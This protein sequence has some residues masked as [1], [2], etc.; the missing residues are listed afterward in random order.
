MMRKFV[1]ARTVAMLVGTLLGATAAHAA[2][3]ALLYTF[4]GG[5]GGGRPNGSLVMDRAGNLYGTTYY[6]GVVNANCPSGCG[7]VFE[8]ILGTNG[9]WTATVVHTFAG[10]NA[11]GGPLSGLTFDSVGNLYGTTSYGGNSTN[12]TGGCGTVFEL[13]PGAGTWS[14]KGIYNFT[15]SSGQTPMGRLLFDSA[16]NLYGTAFQGGSTNCSGGCG[17]VFELMPNSNGKWSWKGLHSFIGGQ[18]GWGP[19]SGLILDAAGN[20]YGTTEWGGNTT[21]SSNGVT[22]FTCGTV[23][24]LTPNLTGQWTLT[25]LH[26]FSGPNNSGNPTG[27]GANPV[28]EVLFDDAGNLYGTT[29]S[30]GRFSSGAEVCGPCGTAF[31]L[32]PASSGPWMEQV[33]HAFNRLDDGNSP[34][35]LVRDSLGNLYGTNAQMGHF[36]GGNIFKLALGTGG[37]WVETVLHAF[38]LPPAN[39]GDTPGGGLLLDNAGNLYGATTKGGSSDQGVVY[40]VTP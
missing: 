3:Y 10:G 17:N 30:S 19:V 9:K 13:T 16:G 25:Q 11:G 8:L 31:E 21:C 22:G 39:G 29:S 7:V 40:E 23:F 36:H 4:N 32:T 12:C 27:D 15:G 26:A 34:Q 6:G 35:S 28:S 18:N 2:S 1:C 37:V 38:Q 5:T 20:L 24:K 33:L 14:W